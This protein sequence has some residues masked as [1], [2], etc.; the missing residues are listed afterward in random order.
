MQKNK[1]RGGGEEEGKQNNKVHRDELVKSYTLQQRKIWEIQRRSLTSSIPP[2]PDAPDD[3]RSI[4][5]QKIERQEQE[6]QQRIRQ[7]YEDEQ[8][9]YQIGSD[10][11]L[12]ITRQVRVR[13]KL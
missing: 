2:K 7:R 13:S 3:K 12:R 9:D 8:R 10:R 6:R 11:K 5:K 1:R 4:Q